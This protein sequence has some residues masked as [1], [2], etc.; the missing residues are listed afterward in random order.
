MS[1]R[2]TFEV[3]LKFSAKDGMDIFNEKKNEIGNQ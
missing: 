2:G 1:K 3:L